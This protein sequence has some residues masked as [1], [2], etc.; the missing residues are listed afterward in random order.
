MEFGT[1]FVDD[2]GVQ[3]GHGWMVAPRSP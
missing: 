2:F 1:S 3:Q